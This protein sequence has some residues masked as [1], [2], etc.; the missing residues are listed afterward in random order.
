M[1]AFVSSPL[2]IIATNC[3]LCS[4]SAVHM[5]SMC[6]ESLDFSPGLSFLNIGSGTGY[7]SAMAAFLCGKVCPSVLE[8]TAYY[9]TKKTENGS[10]SRFRSR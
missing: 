2:F 1:T 3:V 5:Y 10:S 4:H 6:L 8:L 9:G 7:L